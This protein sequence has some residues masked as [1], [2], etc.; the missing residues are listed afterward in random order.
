[1]FLGSGLPRVRV[2]TAR[3]SAGQTTMQMERTFIAIKPDGTNRGLIGEIIARFEKKGYKLVA[4]KAV[5]PSK[6]LAETHYDA[7]KEKPFFG[8]LVEFICSGLVIAMVWEGTGVVKTGRQM[9][10]ATNPLESAPGTIRGDLGIDVGRNVIHG[11][12][13]VETA[14]REIGIWFKPEELVDWDQTVKQWIYE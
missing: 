8:P 14:E 10:G 4:M 9:I 6:E 2:Q 7:L 1:M 3:K 5:K 13:A 11:S 12:D